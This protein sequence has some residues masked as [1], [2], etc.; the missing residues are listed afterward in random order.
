MQPKTCTSLN[1][2]SVFNAT[3]GLE[4]TIFLLQRNV[5]TIKSLAVKFLLIYAGLTGFEPAPHAVTG[6]HC[7]PFN[8]RPI[9]NR[10]TGIT[11]SYST[12]ELCSLRFPCSRNWIRT[13]NLLIF[14]Q[15]KFKVAVEFL[16]L[17]Q[18]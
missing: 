1:E 9:K 12:V 13:N 3:V 4:P 17:L 8:H 6:R 10:H 16:Y 18:G 7:K 11:F 14:S 5:F 15:T 2:G